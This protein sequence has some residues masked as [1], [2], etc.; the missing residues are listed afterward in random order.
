MYIHLCIYIY[1]CTYVY[2]YIYIT[3]YNMFP[4]LKIKALYLICTEKL[5]TFMGTQTLRGHVGSFRLAPAGQINQPNMAYP[6]SSNMA[7]NR[8][9]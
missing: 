9:P 2:V 5:P 7:C 6:G 1:V 3:L 8:K 4:T